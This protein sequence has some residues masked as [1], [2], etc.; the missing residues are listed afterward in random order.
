MRRFADRGRRSRRRRQARAPTQGYEVV[1]IGAS[2]GGR[3]DRRCAARASA[4]DFPLPI[5]LVL[6]INELFAPA[7]AEWLDGQ[8]SRRA[9]Y[10]RDGE[11]VGRTRAASSWRRPTAHLVVRNGRLRLTDDPERHSCRPSVDVLF[12][13]VA[14]E[15]GPP[16][17]LSC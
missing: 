7:F 11:P 1:A 10:A 4:R 17:R 13:S 12:E 14:R 5:L 9:A 2:T 3:R 8:T 6:H 15:Y 16:R